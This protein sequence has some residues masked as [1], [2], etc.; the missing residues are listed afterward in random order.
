MSN[1]KYLIKINMTIQEIN[2]KNF[3]LVILTDT[4]TNLANIKKLQG[5][6]P[7]SQFICLGDITSLWSKA[8]QFN[9]Y[10]IKFFKENKIPVLK[11]NHEEH[12]AQCQRGGKQYIFRA[13]PSFGEYSISQESLDFIQNLPIGFKINLPNGKHYLAFHNRPNDLWSF[14]DSSL[15]E[16]S[17]R[18]I[19]P[20]N[21]DSLGVI[22]GH[23]H[24]QFVVNY[25]AQKLYC[26]NQLAKIGCYALLTEHGLN[27]QNI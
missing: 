21:Q 27:F 3:P 14:T 8:E 16:N 22:I 19:Y 9:E 24:S 15:N 26:V 25:G 13:I 7:F 4:H 18:Q 11:G 23:Q 6:Y 17:F 1:L 5:L 20:V 12:I 2:V 10:S